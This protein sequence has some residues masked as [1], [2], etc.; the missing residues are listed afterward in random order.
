M[1]HN[2]ENMTKKYKLTSKL[3]IETNKKWHKN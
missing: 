1:T 2:L 3:I